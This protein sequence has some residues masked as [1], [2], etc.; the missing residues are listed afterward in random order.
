MKIL[1][2]LPTWLG[3]CIMAFPAI[4]SLL[5]KYPDAEVTMVGSFVSTE[6]FKAHPRVGRVVVDTTHSQPGYLAAISSKRF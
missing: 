3:D 6:L 2:E 4:D 1:I 5:S